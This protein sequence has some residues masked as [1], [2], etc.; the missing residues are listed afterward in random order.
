MMKR[1]E[2]FRMLARHVTD[3]IVIASYS[4]AVDWIELGA[5][6]LNYFSVGAM[7]LD[8]SHGLGLAL[9]RPGQ[10]RHLPARRRQPVDE[11]RHAW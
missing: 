3:E 9:G 5:R 8:S 10:A 4:S 2:C 11:S 7:G 1:D 6:A